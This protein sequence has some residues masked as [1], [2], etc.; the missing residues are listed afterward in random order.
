MDYDAVLTQ[1]LDIL[2]RER[3]VAIGYLSAGSSSMTNFWKTRKM[4]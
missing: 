3:R 4:T 2:Q 1:I